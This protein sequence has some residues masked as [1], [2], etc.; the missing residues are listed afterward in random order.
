MLARLGRSHPLA[1]GSLLALLASC[2]GCASEPT[3]SESAPEPTATLSQAAGVTH[4]VCASGCDFPSPAACAIGAGVTD[5][6]ICLVKGGEYHETV[7]YVVGTLNSDLT[8]RCEAGT[9]CLIDGDGVRDYGFEGYDDWVIEGFEITGTRLAAITG[10]R[11]VAAVRNCYIHDVQGR[12][13]DKISGRATPLPAITAVAENNVIVNTWNHGIVSGSPYAPYIV[14]NN[15]VINAALSAGRAIECGTVSTI[16]HNTV[17]MR[18]RTPPYADPAP[19]GIWGATVRYNVVAGGVTSVGTNLARGGNLVWGWST[20]AYGGTGAADGTDATGDPLFFA[21]EDYHLQSGSPARDTALTSTETLDLD[22]VTRTSPP[23]KGAFEYVAGHVAIPAAWP[24]REIAGNPAT[25]VAPSLVLRPGQGGGPAMAWLDRTTNNLVYA[26]RLANGTWKQETVLAGLTHNVSSVDAFSLRVV[27]L[28]IE[29][30]TGTPAIAYL[31]QNGSNR[32]IHYARRTGDGCGTGCTSPQWAGCNDAPIKTVPLANGV[33]LRLAYH[34]QS[35][36]PALAVWQSIASECGGTNL[37]SRVWFEQRQANDTWVESPVASNVPACTGYI[38]PGIGLSFVPA[39]G[40]AE[41]AFTRTTGFDVINATGALVVASNGGGTFAADVVPLGAGNVTGNGNYSQV[42]IAHQADG[43]VGVAVQAVFGTLGGI[44]L[45]QR[46]AGTWATALEPIRYVGVR[47]VDGIDMMYDAA[48]LPVL[49]FAGERAPWIAHRLATR[50]DVRVVDAQREA[51]T[52]PSLRLTSQGHLLLGHAQYVPDRRVKFQS[53]ADPGGQDPLYQD[54]PVCDQCP[55]DPNKTLPGVCGCGVPDT[56]SDSDGTPD[57]NDLCPS[58]AAKAAPGACGC[59][60]KDNPVLSVADGSV[61]EGDSGTKQ[62]IFVVTTSSACGTPITFQH[63]TSDITAQAGS[64]YVSSSSQSS[65]TA[66]AIQ[67]NIMITVFGDTVYE[68][69]E[70]FALALSSPSVGTFGDGN[71]IGTITNDDNGAPVASGD[72]ISSNEDAPVTADL[73]T[74]DSD[75]NGDKVTVTGVTD[76]PHGTATVNG[77]GTVTYTPD[78]DYYGTDTFDYTVQDGKGGT[79]TATVTV[80]VQ[81]VN[82]NPVAVNDSANVLEG[83]SVD[84][85]V[86][87]ND[88]DVEGNVLSLVSITQ[89]SSGTASMQGNGVVRYTAPA[90]FEGTVTFTYVLSDGNGGTATATVTVVVTALPLPD[91]GPDAQEDA[92]EQDAAEEASPDAE[93]DA[94]EDA[95]AEAAAQDADAEPGDAAQE[96]DGVAEDAADAFI[97]AELEAAADVAQP[98]AAEDALADAKPDAE[99]DAPVDA[100]LDAA[101]DAK[102]DAAAD[103]KLD[104]KQDAAEDAHVDAKLD[105]HVE[106]AVGDGS[107]GAAGGPDAPQSEG[108]GDEGGCGC[109]A[110]GEEPAPSGASWLSLTLLGVIAAF[111]KRGRRAA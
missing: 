13:I 81:P 14:K 75:P 26:V 18:D 77:D 101:A 19:Y 49:A 76:P 36:R 66:G 9:H 47:G 4:T 67:T 86:T 30:L 61:L 20:A 12:G 23:D 107:A 89:P 5:G 110:A 37:G 85:P 55:Q 72:S 73:T 83:A 87:A 3:Q 10:Y 45:A 100:K 21:P 80:T 39:T 105:G 60:F 98:D 44:G 102:L 7:Q 109:R 108:S 35:G 65:F 17:D 70:T 31:K 106:G 41:I 24:V 8:F 58:D 57:C 97:D 38:P 92:A 91:A 27:A 59:G 22:G 84:I 79:S 54:P 50:W 78:K 99:Q 51:G 1:S 32:E 104:A 34:P 25:V 74:N 88:T 94:G 71:A 42:A 29:P 33:S 68:P 28:G 69:N 64:D 93:A 96:P 40:V 63:A 90:G 48:S 2:A 11:R 103:A 52:W 46:T 6:D 16:L 56:D 15:L 43:D 53:T 82:D 95:V 111:R 62:I